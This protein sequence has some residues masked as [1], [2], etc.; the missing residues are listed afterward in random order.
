ML[1][2]HEG[3]WVQ[4]GDLIGHLLRVE[5]SAH[6]HFGAQKGNDWLDPEPFFGASD[7]AE[8]LGLIEMYH[9]GWHL[10]YPAP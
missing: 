10:S 9:P 7:L 8:I 5:D 1:A 2:V 6:I 4:K 3:D